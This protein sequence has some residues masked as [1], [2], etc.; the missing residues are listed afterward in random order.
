M[1]EPSPEAGQKLAAARAGSAEALGQTLQA[2]RNYLLAIAGQELDPDL[3]SKG[4]ASDL[5]QETFLEAQRAFTNFQ[6]TN[7]KELLAWLRQILVNNVANFSRRYHYA[8]RTVDREI[9]LKGD[10]SAQPAGALP[11]DP[12][13]TPSS[14]AVKREQAAALER[15]LERL[16]S[17]YRQ[18]IKLRYF[19]GRSFE[20]IGVLM[21][22]SPEAVR[23]LWS[24]G[25]ERLRQE[26]EGL[27]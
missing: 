16:P 14:E 15:T 23:K 2:C 5:V 9:E 10:D 21:N 18:A 3:R 1:S 11:P 8:K 20:E 6:G 12:Q 4:G 26:W 13:R 17:D 22:R 25:M 19:E 24:R 27:P 7:E